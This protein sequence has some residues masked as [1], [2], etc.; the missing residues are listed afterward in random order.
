MILHLTFSG[1]FYGRE[2]SAFSLVKA[3][4]NHADVKIL[5]VVETRAKTFEIDDLISKLKSF[6]L[7][8][9][10][11]QTDSVFSICT[12]RE[13]SNYISKTTPTIIH[14]HCHKSVVYTALI[15][16]LGD[17]KYKLIFTL[18]GL[19]FPRKLSSLVH[20]FLYY[21]SIFMSDKVIGCSKLLT[22]NL[23]KFPFSAGKICTIPNAYDCG[24]RPPISRNEALSRVMKLCGDVSGKV[25]IANI[26]RLTAIKNP[27]MFLSV[28]KK[29]K[30]YCSPRGILFHFIMAGDGEL[31]Q[32]VE[33]T[34][35][36][37]SIL[38]C[39][40][41]V[42]YVSEIEYIYPAFDILVMTSDSEGSPMCILEAMSNKLPVVA[43]KVGGI[44]DMIEDGETGLLYAKRDEDKCLLQLVSLINSGDLR[45]CIGEQAHASYQSRYTYRTWVQKHLDCYS[46]W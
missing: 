4:S 17:Y 28:V 24:T 16:L 45:K 46:S 23:M 25:L 43:P 33:A 36:D 11:L 40:S 6:G 37:Y 9:D 42:G 12:Y 30:D 1:K 31:R 21:L 38:D 5:V 20:Y 26:G 27:M 34:A 2:N 18:H 10:L 35:R 32:A 3:L 44:P 19:D 14:C 22:A 13:L 29:V 15:K 41:I 8:Y 7:N 39:L